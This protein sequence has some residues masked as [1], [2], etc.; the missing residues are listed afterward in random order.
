MLTN[1]VI[2][3]KKKESIMT[4]AERISENKKSLNPTN[5]FGSKVIPEE[6]GGNLLRKGDII[7]LPEK[8]IFGEGDDANVF[9][10]T[11]GKTTT[12]VI[13]ATLTRDGVDSAI[14]F[15]PFSLI[16]NIFV[17]EMVGE[18]VQLKLPVLR[19]LGTAVEKILSFRNHKSTNGKTNFHAAM[20][21]LQGAKIHISEDTVVKSQKWT[22]GIA[23]NALKDTHVYTYDLV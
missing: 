20:E 17:A 10:Q 11:F 22:D 6:F 3:N 15:Y 19:P 16:K 14:N 4:V 23:Q 5:D 12:P 21:S 9:S 8:Y 18:K 2:I 1:V 13:V 7:S